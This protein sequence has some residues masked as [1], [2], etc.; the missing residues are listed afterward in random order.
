MTRTRSL[1]KE[2]LLLFVGSGFLISS[3][4]GLLMYYEYHKHIQETYG[5]MLGQ[6]T[7]MFVHTYP[8]VLDFDYIVR[9]GTAGSEEYWQLARELQAIA[10]AF[11]LMYISVLEK[12]DG[13]YVFILDND[14]EDVTGSED[15]V[16]GTPYDFLVYGTHTDTMVLAEKTGVMQI[17]PKPTTDEYGTF[18]SSVYPI[19]KN[20]GVAG[21]ITIDMD[22]STSKALEYPARIALIVSLTIALGVSLLLGIAVSSSLIKP[23]RRTMTALQSIAEGNL[24]SRIQA[25]RQDELGDMM[26]FLALTQEKIKILIKIIAEKAEKL[27]LVGNELSSMMIQSAA[28]IRQI[29]TQICGLKVKAGNQA[30]SLTQTNSTMEGIVRSIGSLNES[31]EKQAESVS[32]SSSAIE[33]MASHIT[34]VSESLTLNEQN[35]EKLTASYEKGHKALRRVS[36]DIQEVAKK[37][38]R[39]L[40]I[41]GVIEHIANQTHMLSMNAAIEAAHAGVAGK[42]FAVVAGEIRKLAESSSKQAGSVGDILKKIKTALDGIRDSTEKALHHFMDIDRN[43]HIVADQEGHIRQAMEEQNMGS[44]QILLTIATSQEITQNVRDNAAAMLSGSDHVINES[45]QLESLTA[46]LD[47]GMDEIAA[48]IDQINAAVTRIQDVSIENRDSIMSLVAEIGKF[49]V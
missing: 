29:N 5:K 26:R 2:F 46:D 49:T 22:V 34:A 32:R 12:R 8:Q 15:V 13:Q 44:R 3:G 38:E 17:T 19:M 24:T 18:I 10:D 48:G 41:N 27:S 6:V 35:I 4:V 36:E 45:K 43:V 42:G 9:E 16:P 39:L 30:E 31:I 1:K 33:E 37:S 23:I 28:A 40:E 47:Q 7:T 25:D 21:I 14:I 20:G 11:D